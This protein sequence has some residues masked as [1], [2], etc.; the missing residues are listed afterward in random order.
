MLITPVVASKA[1][2]SL[3][4]TA[5]VEPCEVTEENVP[6]RNIVLPICTIARTAP[7]FT[8]GVVLTGTWLTKVG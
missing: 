5:V 4:V 7:L 1:T 6:P 2:M 3:R 8:A